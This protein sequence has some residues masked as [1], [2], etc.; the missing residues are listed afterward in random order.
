M[1]NH[2]FEGI[3]FS[4]FPATKDEPARV[5]ITMPNNTLLSRTSRAARPHSLYNHLNDQPRRSM[6]QLRALDPL[7]SL[8]TAEDADFYT[9]EGN[10]VL[11]V[12]CGCEGATLFRVLTSQLAKQSEFFRSLCALPQPT[13]PTHDDME[14]DGCPVIRNDVRPEDVRNTFKLLW[15]VP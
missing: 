13:K 15:D 10:I 6:S 12:S 11:A 5:L 8:P 9:P 14:H 7:L 4:G 2:P 3:S 1:I